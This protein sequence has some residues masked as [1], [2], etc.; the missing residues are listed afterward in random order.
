[1]MCVIRFDFFFF[2]ADDDGLTS[3]VDNLPPDVTVEDRDIYKQVR[4]K[5]L[6][7]G[8]CHSSY[9]VDD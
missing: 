9:A 3:E 4:E 8:F 1:V 7:V 2:L 5:A 6:E